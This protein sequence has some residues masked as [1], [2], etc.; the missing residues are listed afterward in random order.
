MMGS[1]QHKIQIT[2]LVIS[3]GVHVSSRLSVTTCKNLSISGNGNQGVVALLKENRQAKIIVLITP[4]LVH[5]M[6]EIC[7]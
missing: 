2:A 7:K 1:M 3:Y 4:L 6:P 5:S